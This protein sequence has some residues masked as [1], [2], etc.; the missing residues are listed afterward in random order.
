[1][2][3]N[4]KENDYESYQEDEDEKHQNSSENNSAKNGDDGA[5]KENP[6]FVV[7]W[8]TPKSQK[9]IKLTIKEVEEHEMSTTITIHKA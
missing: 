7:D 5:A 1:M 6:Y 4:E 9:A 2:Y 8:Q 3:W